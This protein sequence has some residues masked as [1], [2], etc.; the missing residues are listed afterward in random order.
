MTTF[1]CKPKI[2]RYVEHL[3]H[4]TMA[5]LLASTW[6]LVPHRFRRVLSLAIAFVTIGSILWA[7]SLP[8]HA[9]GWSTGA[10]LHQ[11]TLKERLSTSFPYNFSSS[12]PMLMWQT[13]KT[14][15]T[16]E[17]FDGRFRPATT[18]W[19]TLNPDFT[20]EVV[21]D[22]AAVELFA[23]IPAVSEAYDA[24]PK[25]VLKADFFRY[26][27]LLARGGVY[28]DIDTTALK[29]VSRWAPA[30]LEPFGLAVGIEADPDRPDWHDWYARRIQFCQWTIMSKPGHPVLVDIVASITEETLKRKAQDELRP[31]LMKSV[32]EFTGP[33]VWTDSI[34]TYLNI[35]QLLD[36]SPTPSSSLVSWQ[37]FANLREPMKVSDV[38]IL[39]ITSFSPGVGHMGSGSTG[40]RLAFVSH[41]F[42]GN[43][44]LRTNAYDNK[45]CADLHAGTWKHDE[46]SLDNYFVT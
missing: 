36:E 30:E 43:F 14:S 39:P 34:F 26:L 21:T 9:P 13:W 12:L 40:D 24:L 18:S 4:R 15:P 3:S 6:N 10:W 25:P 11:S 46:R 19:D 23:G 16:D 45:K 35:T 37:I 38:L 20:H 17:A 7:I 42:S 2:L 31:A 5:D 27:I 22:A 1:V 41:G 44:S 29:S 28:S 8:Q 32:M 33:G